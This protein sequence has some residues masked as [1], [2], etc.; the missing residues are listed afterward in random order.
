M[1]DSSTERTLT[2]DNE[3]EIIAAQDRALNTKY[4]A[5]KML[6]TADDAKCK[7]ANNLM[8]HYNT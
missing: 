3:S 2:V 8:I 1:P 5:T 4:C 6:K 7:Y